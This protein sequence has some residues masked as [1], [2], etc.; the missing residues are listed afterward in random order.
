MLPTTYKCTSV[1][2]AHVVRVGS[3][4]CIILCDTERVECQQL[5]FS[6]ESQVKVHCYPAYLEP[7][8]SVKIKLYSF[9][10]LTDLP[11]LNSWTCAESHPLFS[12]CFLR[13]WTRYPRMSSS[14]FCGPSMSIWTESCLAPRTDT[15]GTAGFEPSISVITCSILPRRFDTLHK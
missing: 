5:I 4:E 8:Q 13:Y 11:L 10:K 12:S 3:L 2:E 1:Y 9:Q 6:P 7:N 15:F 14:S